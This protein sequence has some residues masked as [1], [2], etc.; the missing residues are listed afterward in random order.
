MVY[1]AAPGLLPGGFLGVDVFFVISGYLITGILVTSDEPLGTALK[2]FWV[3][4]IRRILPA[5]MVCILGTL[6]LGM[7]ILPP[8]PFQTLARSAIAAVFSVSNILFWRQP[9]GYFHEAAGDN[10]LIHTWSLGVEEQFY[11]LYPL[12]LLILARWRRHWLVPALVAGTVLSFAFALWLKSQS[13]AAAFYL[14]PSRAWELGV[15]ALTWFAA[16]RLADRVPPAWAADALCL[17]ALVA[18]TGSL[19]L[20]NGQTGSVGWGALPAVLGAALLIFGATSTRGIGRLLSLKVLVGIGLISYSLYLWHQPLLALSRVAFADFANLRT[21]IM[22]LILL[23]SFPLAWASWRFVERPLRSPAFAPAKA[24]GGIALAGGAVC[25]LAAV[26]TAQSGMPARFSPELLQ[27]VAL[28]DRENRDR[29]KRGQCALRNDGWRSPPGACTSPA[30]AKPTIA[31]IGDS[32]ASA[33]FPIIA[34]EAEASGKSAL[35]MFAGRCRPVTGAHEP[36]R[37]RDR[38]NKYPLEVREYLAATPSVDT[39]ILAYH[40]NALVEPRAPVL[41]KVGA[42][43]EVADLVRALASDGR[44]VLLM[45]PIPMPDMPGIP[46]AYAA[47]LGDRPI[48]VGIPYEEYRART[49]PVRAMLDQVQVDRLQ[50]FDP[51]TLLCDAARNACA[52][53]KDGS[54]LFR[55]RHHLTTEGAAIALRSGLLEAALEG[56]ENQARAFRSTMYRERSTD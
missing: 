46:A 7:A 6:L 3:R 55:D 49:A 56:P 24:L 20:L 33:L 16:Q 48:P 42:A 31:V 37:N 51:G 27:V 22:P 26:I 52:L 36:K 35:L 44:R 30:G 54:I 14:L 1:H 38:C 13:P 41:P 11:L 34:Q 2:T 53:S 15:G 17:L 8:D 23:A 45:D 9:R 47:G 50:R 28:Q 39:I 25:A 32:H 12:L 43:E 29:I 10:P 21:T 5:L 4:R 40:W 18:I 19:V